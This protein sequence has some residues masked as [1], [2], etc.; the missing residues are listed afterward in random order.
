MPHVPSNECGCAP[1]VGEL[2]ALG[3][4]V[5]R[6]G[7]IG[8]SLVGLATVGLLAAS[9]AFAATY[10]SWDDVERAKRNERSKA[11]EVSRIEGLISSLA[12]D[13]AHKE[14]EA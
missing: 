4:G 5:T 8:L 10:P 14:A 1:T 13:L 6:R 9:P 2:R 3:Q 11:D 7:V 12:A